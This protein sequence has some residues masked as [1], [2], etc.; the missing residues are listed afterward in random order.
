M[1]IGSISSASNWTWPVG[2]TGRKVQKRSHDTSSSPPSLLGTG[3]W[4]ALIG[5]MVSGAD[6]TAVPVASLLCQVLS[7]TVPAFVSQISK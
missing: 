4:K 1:C 5:L 7:V 2:S 6:A 3:F